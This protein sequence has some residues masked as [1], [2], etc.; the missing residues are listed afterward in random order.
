M[1]DEVLVETYWER[2]EGLKEIFPKSLRNGV[3]AGIETS[4]SLFQFSKQAIWVVSTTALIM[5]LPYI[6]EKERAD[7]EKMQV[8]QQRQMLLGP[9]AALPQKH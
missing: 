8:A 6:V 9:Q 2:I 1:A 3:S 7:N 4:W 5:V